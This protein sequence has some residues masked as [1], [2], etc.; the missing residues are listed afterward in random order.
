M[1]KVNTIIDSL[2]ELTLIEAAELVTAIEET[3]NVSAAAPVAVAGAASAA[4]PVEAAAA[5]TEFTVEVTE[6]PAD[7]KISVIKEVKTILNLGLSEAK[8]KVESA[9]FVV[10]EKVSKEEADKVKNALSA[11][12]ATVTVK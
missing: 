2:K 6:V 11:A 10:V 9:P 1:S 3:F 12:G 7:K 4:A 5:Q 8:T